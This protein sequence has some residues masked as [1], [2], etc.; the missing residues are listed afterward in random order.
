MDSETR[1]RNQERW[2]SDE[3]PVLVGTIAFGL[4]I[5]KAAVRAVIH[6]ALP[7]SIEQYYQEAGRAGRDGQASDCIL[8][9]QKRDVG[10]LT[11]FI[12]Q[13]EDEAEKQRSWQRYHEILRF[14]QSFTCR[15]RQIC[16]HFGETPKWTSCG[17]CDVCIA[18]PEWLSMP[19]ISS[20]SRRRKTAPYIAGSAT[21][22]AVRFSAP[23][24]FNGE[25]SALREALRQWR[26]SVAKQQGVAAFAVMHDS[27]LDELCQVKPDSV[28]GIRE[29]HGF[30]ERKT[31]RFGPE[32]LNI[33]RQFRDAVSARPIPETKLSEIRLPE[34]KSAARIETM[35]L[36]R[37]GKTLEEI[38]TVRERQ[39]GS[40]VE[41]VADI[42]QRGE[43][44]FQPAWVDTGRYALIEAA[45]AQHGME[46][47]A[48]LKQA[49]PEEITFH[50]I[51]LVVAH[52]RRKLKN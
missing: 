6:L 44:D 51:R 1:K 19:V 17:A 20:R 21:R 28:E 13:I 10:L 22:Q 49:L 40:I 42:V 45:C 46:L 33:I 11:Y 5:N 39:L 7:K 23:G 8:L 4:G 9:W 38:A 25:N 32:I 37:Q 30:G 16:L 31:E 36:L 2:T 14:V 15:H 50:D 34:K 12:D 41:M 27:M 47:L 43:F 24:A 29:I 3:V 18:A 35:R 48:P 52:L 26:L